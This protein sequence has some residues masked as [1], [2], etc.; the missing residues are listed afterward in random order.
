MWNN[1]ETIA[2]IKRGAD[3]QVAAVLAIGVTKQ[4]GQSVGILGSDR[5]SG[6]SCIE[7]KRVGIGSNIAEIVRGVPVLKATDVIGNGFADA[8][9]VATVNVDF[10]WTFQA[11]ARILDPGNGGSPGTQVN[12]ALGS[13]IN[14][15]LQGWLLARLRKTTVAVFRHCT[16]VVRQGVIWF[17]CFGLSHG[18]ARHEQNR[19]SDRF[20]EGGC[21]LMLHGFSSWIS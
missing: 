2:Q 14:A 10:H 18:S 8:A 6:Q 17:R 13:K 4:I 9:F 19:Q 15:C 21:E 3:V 5:T 7:L 11:W 16:H 20:G 1:R 12:A